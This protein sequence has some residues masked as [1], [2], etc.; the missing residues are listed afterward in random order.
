MADWTASA[1]HT[2]EYWKVDPSTWRDSEPLGLVT[3]CSIT[4]DDSELMGSADLDTDEEIEGEVY[5]RAY[6]IVEQ[7]AGSGN[8]ERFCLFT[9][10]AQ[11]PKRKMNGKRITRSL[12]CYPPTIEL[13]DTKPPIGYTVAKGSN[14]GV[15][16]EQICR[17]HCRAPIMTI[18]TTSTLDEPLV[19]SDSDSWLTFVQALLDKGGLT[20]AIDEWGRL[21]FPPEKDV[22][23]LS[24]VWTYDDSN[25]SILLPEV[26]EERDWFG[27]P[28]VYEAVLSKNDKVLVGRAVNDSESSHLSTVSRGREVYERETSPDVPEGATQEDLA[29][30]AKAKLRELSCVE[31]SVEYQ[32]GFNQ[33]RV[34]DS[35]GIDYT[36]HGYNVTA[37]VISQKITCDTACT[38]QET[39]KFTE[40]MWR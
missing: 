11:S 36:V 3:S 39:A 19:A 33:V 1:G 32:H 29:N 8:R 7:P 35:V 34:G 38:V 28:N 10:L 13:K 4:R 15:A 23:S 26:D 37:K 40:D 18:S 5:I 12:T 25:S 22:S 9:F 2:Y 14:V 21:S 24:P 20:M 6:L 31:R 30:Y 16:A 17:A 27:V